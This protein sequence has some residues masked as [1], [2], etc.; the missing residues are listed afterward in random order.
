MAAPDISVSQV[1]FWP[2]ADIPITLL[3]VR[4]LR[5][6]AGIVLPSRCCPL[7]GLPSSYVGHSTF[8]S[9]GGHGGGLI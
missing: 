4:F 7:S 2:L 9:P 5:R 8:S 3:N 1:G 6:G